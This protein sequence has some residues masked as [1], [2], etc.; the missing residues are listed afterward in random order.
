MSASDHRNDD[1]K[2]TRDAPVVD[3]D[4]SPGASKT[5]GDAPGGGKN[6]GRTT[7]GNKSPVPVVPT[8]FGIP[9]EMWVDLPRMYSEATSLRTS[10]VSY[11]NVLFS[12]ITLTLTLGNSFIPPPEF[13]CFFDFVTSGLDILTFTEKLERVA[14]IRKAGGD[15]NPDVA[16]LYKEGLSDRISWYWRNSLADKFQARGITESVSSFVSRCTQ[17]TMMDELKKLYPH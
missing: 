10:D 6:E 14:E 1:Q 8:F 7:S 15:W 17:E 9:F 4:D 12:R 3:N 2:C 11:S 16:E 5:T 13:T